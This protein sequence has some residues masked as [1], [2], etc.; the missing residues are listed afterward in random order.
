MASES[1][2]NMQKSKCLTLDS[3][4]KALSPI[5]IANPDKLIIHLSFSFSKEGIVTISKA[6]EKSL[7]ELSK[8]A[9]LL[10]TLNCS[11]FGKA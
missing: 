8:K 4:D 11:I 2:I 3:F 1:W 10:R 7:T 9:D 5:L 6:W